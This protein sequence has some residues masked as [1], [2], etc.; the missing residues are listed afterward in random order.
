MN[1]LPTIKAQATASI[2]VRGSSQVLYRIRLGSH[3]EGLKPGVC[4]NILVQY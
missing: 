3:E 4:L 1:T 2:S